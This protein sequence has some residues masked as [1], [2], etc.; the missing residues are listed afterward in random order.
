MLVP[1]ISFWSWSVWA[2]LDIV[3]PVVSTL[4]LLQRFHF[5]RVQYNNDRLKRNEKKVQFYAFCN[6]DA[7]ISYEPHIR[8]IPGEKLEINFFEALL[9]RF[10]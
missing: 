6:I 5:L 3:Y 2:C 1:I 4:G 9:M 7:Y 8:E 10:G